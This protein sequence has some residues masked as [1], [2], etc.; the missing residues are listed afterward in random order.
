[1]PGIVCI[2]SRSLDARARLAR[3]VSS[4]MHEP[5]Y[6]SGSRSFDEFGLHLGW[7][8]F[9]SQ[10]DPDLVWNTSRNIG[11]LFSGD[12]VSDDDPGSRLHAQRLIA[13]YERCGEHFAE[14]LNGTFT[15]VVVDL[16]RSIALLF[17]D[18][19]GASRV[20][21]RREAEGVYFA[22]EA[23]A[24]LCVLPRLRH[25]DATGLAQTLS[26]GCTLGTRTLFEGITTLPPATLCTI[27]SD[28]NVR[29]QQYFDRR[30]W[31]A[32][33]RLNESQFMQSLQDVFS[34]R[35]PAYLRG[36]SR[37]AMSL[38]GGLD[39][40]LVLAWARP[41]ANELPCYTFGGMYRECHDER[42]ARSVARALGQSHRSLRVGPAMLDDFAALAAQATYVSDGTMDVSGAVEVYANRCAREVA[43]VRL[44]GNY[45]SEILRGHVA[46]RPRAVERSWLAPGLEPLLDEARALYSDERHGHPVSFVAFKQV[47]WH[48]HARRTVEQSQIVVRSPFLDNDL[49]KLMMRA[50]EHLLHSPG[51]S[52]QLIEAAN[53]TLA[54]MATDRGYR[55]APPTLAQRLRQGMSGFS[56]KAEYAYD[57]GMP[58]ALVK[59]DRVL[60][61][62][63]PERLFLGRHKFYHFRV[64]YQRELRGYLRDTL[65][66]RRALERNCYQP[67]VLTRLVE[68]HTSARANHTLE[69][70]RALT[71]ELTQQQLFDR[72]PAAAT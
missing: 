59:L 54:A 69:L 64:W 29:E 39:G 40:R 15:A 53:P 6:R 26:T 28:G 25:F 5:W 1:M 62:F 58:H 27:T 66:S 68:E 71:V 72:W 46:F 12:E 70:H 13:R 48:H 41:R 61:P 17:N 67:Q 9:N 2:V 34:R 56:A 55:N 14:S 16:R 38:T 36:P 31:E 50:P 24:L 30:S 42:I 10:P 20:H 21:V 43:P 19:F 65:L 3:M 32:E 63:R 8:G 60:A 22:S 44:T 49:V 23:K 52:L 45:G 57:Y 35:V 18:R 51:P 7:T 4:M 37:N 11:L 47:P 33:D